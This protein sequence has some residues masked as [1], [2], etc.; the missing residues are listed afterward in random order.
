MNKS[1]SIDEAVRF[2]WEVSKKN[3]QFFVPLLLIVVAI[4]LGLNYLGEQISDDRFV[5]F[6]ATLASWP[7]LAVISLGQIN[8]SLKFVDNKKA[9]LADLF[10]LYPLTLKYFLADLLY[11]LAV[12]I[13]L[14]LLIVPGI[15]FG[16]KLRYY[17][18]FIAEKGLGPIEA[19]EKSWEITGG[20]KWKLFLFWLLLG[21][22]NI[23]GAL[24]LVVGL[25][26]TVPLTM[27][28]QAYVYKKL[29]SGS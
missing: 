18:Y 3:W 8:I 27:V 5:R 25:F 9:E 6:L 16:I 12:G 15:I 14:L 7:V 23:A 21:L 22:I 20:V 24:V 26:L 19:L 1:F 11:A 4:E 28:A 10:R 13:G 29:S 17:G 2:G